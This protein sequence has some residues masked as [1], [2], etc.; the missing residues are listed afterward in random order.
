[1]WDRVE[2]PG[3]VGVHYIGVTPADQPVH[4]LGV[5]V[6]SVLNPTLSENRQL[7]SRL[8]TPRERLARS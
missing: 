2:I 5:I 4:L 6:E 8:T 1:M 3:E 7:F